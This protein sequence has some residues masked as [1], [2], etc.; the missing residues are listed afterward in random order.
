MYCVQFVYIF[1]CA[2]IHVHGPHLLL[3]PQISQLHGSLIITLRNP[4]VSLPGII[5]KPNYVLCQL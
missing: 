3:W 5:K 1:V 4:I 2:H